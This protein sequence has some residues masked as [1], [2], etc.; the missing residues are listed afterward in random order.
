MPLTPLLSSYSYVPALGIN[1]DGTRAYAV[2]YD[3]DAE[4]QS[5]SVI[6]T[7]PMSLPYNTEI[8]MITERT[9]ALSPDGTRRYVAQADGRTVVVYNI[10]TNTPI[11]AFTTDQ[12]GGTSPRSIAVASDGTLYITDAD[13]NK[14]YIVTV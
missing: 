2:V 13:D 1:A 6:D 7:N 5:I 11:G 10:A 14:V 12:N 8:A 4:G 9:T 3:F